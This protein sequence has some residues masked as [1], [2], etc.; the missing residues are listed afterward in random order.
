MDDMKIGMMTNI[1]IIAGHHIRQMYNK[2][3]HSREGIG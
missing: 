1:W 3:I 2:R